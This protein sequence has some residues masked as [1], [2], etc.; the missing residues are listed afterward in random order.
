MDFKNVV[1][2]CGEESRSSNPILSA[3]DIFTK[4][5][6]GVRVRILLKFPLFMTVSIFSAVV[7]ILTFTKPIV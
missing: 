2:T 4:D 6:H 5:K 3:L 7:R 1:D